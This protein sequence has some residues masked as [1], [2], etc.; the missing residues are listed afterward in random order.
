MPESDH[1]AKISLS[2]A[3][4]VATPTDIAWSQAYNIGNVFVC[5]SLTS[6]IS[7]E[8]TSL[9]AVGKEFFNTLQSEFFTLE[10]KNIASIKTAI[11]TSLEKVPE[12]ITASLTFAFFK[13]STLLI[14]IA[15]SGKVIMK[16]GGK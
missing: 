1:P 4:L 2:F 12:Q 11:Q 6:D 9:Q 5:I 7:T 16:R 8:E 13:E 3:K 14:F 10:E 15:G